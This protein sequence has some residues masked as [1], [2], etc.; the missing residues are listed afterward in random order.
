LDLG[1]L[2]PALSLAKNC[3]KI[4]ETHV[5]LRPRPGNF[6]Y[7]ESEF[8]LILEDLVHFKNVGVSGVVFGFLDKN[9]NIDLK[10]T[11]RLILEA[12]KLNLHT[13]F[14]RAFDFIEDKEKTLLQL[15]EMGVDRV[16]TSGGQPTAIEGIETIKTLSKLAQGRIEIMAGSGISAN[17]ILI[18]QDAGIDAAHFSIRQKIESM[19]GKL[20]MGNN[21]I[22]DENKISD[23]LKTLGR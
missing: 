2:S 7:S 10:N 8:K 20:G 3:S 6:V 21:T 15:I 18:F 4:I 19:E 9:N 11:G 23:L 5:M 12:K 22:P 14:H 13:T 16:L 17:N 1:G